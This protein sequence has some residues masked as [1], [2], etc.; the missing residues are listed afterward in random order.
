MK[1]KVEPRNYEEVYEG[2]CGIG[3]TLDDLRLD[4]INLM[5]FDSFP[6]LPEASGVPEIQAEVSNRIERL[7]QSISELR[8][9]L[10][11]EEE[12]NE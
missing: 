2:L 7:Y 5:D 12:N 10:L 6:D 3:N 4:I 9:E 11:A 1:V 8:H